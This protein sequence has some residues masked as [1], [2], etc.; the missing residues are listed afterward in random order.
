[1]FG[2]IAWKS[3]RARRVARNHRSVAEAVHSGWAD[4]GICVELT[5]SEAGLVFLP[6]QEEAYDLCVPNALLDDPRVGALLKVVRSP[7]YKNLLTPLPGY[8]TKET[9]DLQRVS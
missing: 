7:H 9:G 8:T 5:S 2:S 6:V 1:M 3:P 4:A